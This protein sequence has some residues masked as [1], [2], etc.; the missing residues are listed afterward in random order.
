M[1]DST[2][3]GEEQGRE[4][5]ER[6]RAFVQLSFASGAAEKTDG[7]MP[8]RGDKR[9]HW[10]QKKWFL[11]RSVFD[12][13]LTQNEL[14]LYAGVKN[15]SSLR[16]LH[17][18][19]LAALWFASPE[20]LQRQFPLSELLKGEN[21]DWIQRQMKI[22]AVQQAREQARDTISHSKKEELSEATRQRRSEAQIRRW[23][24][25]RIAKVQQAS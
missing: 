8:R 2:V 9:R 21:R 6:T 10:E 1:L 22:R 12:D 11:V 3:I 25:E 4:L 23:R 20:E 13:T 16:H 14:L 24:R 17:R 5:L 18:H 7:A 19:A 15:L